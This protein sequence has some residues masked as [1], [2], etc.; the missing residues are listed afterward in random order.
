MFGRTAAVLAR[1]EEWI[2]SLMVLQMGLSIFLQVVMRYVFN[3][4][5]TWLDELVHIEVVLLTFFGAALGVKYGAHISVDALKNVVKGRSV[6]L[7]DAINHVVIAV[8]SGLVITFGYKLIVLMADRHHLTPTLRIPK[9][10]L[11]AAV[12]VGL[13]LIC[14]RSL[15]QAWRSLAALKDASGGAAS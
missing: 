7:L 13:A 10:Y 12:C 1:I 8:Y 6:H 11:Y 4:A 14:L 5:V 2:L 15:F 3:S 9:H